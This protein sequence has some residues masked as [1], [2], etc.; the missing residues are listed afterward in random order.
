MQE[1]RIYQKSELKEGICSCCQEQSNAILKYDTRCVDC[2]EESLFIEQTMKGLG[3]EYCPYC[4]SLDG[5]DCV[6][7]EVENE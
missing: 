2:I 6:C 3:E 7:D 5:F 4:G 1:E